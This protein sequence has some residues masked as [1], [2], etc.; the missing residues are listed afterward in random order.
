M[1]NPNKELY[2]NRLAEVIRT[3]ATN[4][5]R[6]NFLAT[7]TP[8][9]KLIHVTSGIKETGK[10]E[11]DEET[12]FHK[13]VLKRRNDH[14]FII[15]QGDN[16]TGKSHFI[17]WVKERYE[18]EVN[19]DE[20]AVLFISRSQ[21]T[22]RGALEQ[23]INSGVFEESD[24]VDKIKKLIL[25]NEHLK[26]ND[27]KQNIIHQFAIAVLGDEESE[28]IPSKVKKNLYAFLVEPSIQEFMFRKMGPID[29]IKMRLA[30]ESSNQ[31]LDDI[32]PRFE[33][34]DFIVTVD[35]L[36]TFRQSDASRRSMRLAEML[37]DNEN[38]AQLRMD[39]ANYLNLFLETVVQRCAN[40]RGSD[41]KDVFQQLR[42]EL[43]ANNKNLTLFIEDITSFTGID[44]A[45]VE[46][47]VT[48][49]KG[50]DYNEEFC[51]LL[52]FVGITNDY[53][54]TT[55]PDNLKE[56]VT[57]R[58]LI[59]KAAL[60]DGNQISE[61]AAR[62]INAIYVKQGELAK[63]VENGAED[64]ILPI[65]SDYKDFEWSNFRLQDNRTVTLFPF[66]E[67]ALGNFYNA[68][69]IKTPRRFL[70]YV[71]THLLQLYFVNDEFP[72]K[73]TEL[74][75]EFANLPNFK[76]VLAKRTIENKAPLHSER[77]TSFLRVWGNG[78]VDTIQNNNEIIVGGL[79][80]NA[81]DVFGLPFI[82]DLNRVIESKGPN[83]NI[84]N[85]GNSNGGNR[86]INPD[87]IVPPIPQ[88]TTN[89]GQ[90]A[91][92]RVVLELDQW[93]N[94]TRKLKSYSHFRDDIYNA[95]IE[96][97]DWEAE[98]VS[99]RLVS[100]NFQSRKIHIEDQTVTTQGNEI[101]TIEK[102]STTY[103]AFLSMAAWRH[104]GNKSWNFEGAIDYLPSF[105]NWLHEK[106]DNVINFI[107]FPK[108]VSNHEKWEYSKWILTAS[109][110]LSVLSGNLN[111]SDTSSLKIYEALFNQPNIP[112]EEHRSSDWVSMQKRLNNSKTKLL[113][114]TN[115]DLLKSHYNRV[116]GKI[117]DK[118]EVHFIDVVKVLKE[119]KLLKRQNWDI[120]KM[121]LP[122]NTLYRESTRYTS[123][124]LLEFLINFLPLA[125]KGECNLI[126]QRIDLITKYIGNDDSVGT[127][128]SEVRDLLVY[129]KSINEGFISEDF[130]SLQKR[131]LNHEQLLFYLNTLRQVNEWE[132]EQLFLGL[133]TIPSER[134]VDYIK[135]FENMERLLANKYVRF[136]EKHKKL[137]QKL[138]ES[139]T[140]QVIE[141]TLNYLK[142]LQ[143]SI[144]DIHKEVSPN[145]IG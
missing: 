52:S 49:H 75:S 73:I 20:E 34:D 11:M 54:K 89:P 82:P 9:K 3:D 139:Q 65:S 55:I 124:Q 145:V 140:E 131:E 118:T 72:P 106:K 96:F 45:L 95:F 6:V 68:M 19:P 80:K 100:D 64:G 43:R 41:L 53:Y 77:L 1:S 26:E 39:L 84:T 117:T 15:V 44:R 142:N 71:L 14:Q 51:R 88:I 29:R 69:E 10:S 112:V 105:Y 113:V 67:T 56:R 143:S 30:A 38:A 108:E 103:Y 114:Q 94:E 40:L 16:G 8:F 98:D 116:Q 60:F 101:F 23:I 59:D 37:F 36:Q 58:V 93:I 28:T 99:S 104:L 121:T 134:V 79:P 63:W 32:S 47:L 81:F 4:I 136:E 86:P 2:L 135:L 21:S 127:L 83:T 7:H 66:N 62:Y 31:R 91:F 35:V 130:I 107:K 85:D 97:I 111:R 22:L 141:D 92:D 46:V 126:Q 70:K 144:V 123:L 25:A 138:K 110:H 12:F 42:K 50:T 33:G 119:I 27:L 102:S 24:S 17:R 120:G 129:F 109:Y 5:D 125:I 132:N 76:D 87:P 74:T 18:N 57:S 128:F 137:V 115:Y 78:N 133:I 90:D 122:D 61:M 13:Q 48:E